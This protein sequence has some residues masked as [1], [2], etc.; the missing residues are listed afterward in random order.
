MAE[1][2]KKKRQ[3]YVPRLLLR[4]FSS[5]GESVAMVVLDTEKRI[6]TASIATQCQKPYFYGEDERLE[7]AFGVAESKFAKVLG[8]LARTH[9]DQRSDDDLYDVRQF[10]HYQRIRTVAAA[11]D[12]N[13]LFDLAF[14]QIIKHDAA[15]PDVDQD[16]FRLVVKDTQLRILRE[17]TFSTPL[18][19]DLDVKF[20]VSER[21]RGF[22]ITDHPVVLQN[23]WAEHHLRFKVARSTTGL[24][25]K[26]L[27]MFLPVSP[28]VCVCV[29]DPR[30]YAYGSPKSRTFSVG[31]R[32]I[33]LLNSL[34]VLNAYDSL[35]FD[36][37]ATP[38]EELQRLLK[39]RSAN[40][41]WRVHELEEGPARRRIDGMIGIPMSIDGA[42]I[43]LGSQ[44]NFVQVTD[45]HLYE[46]HDARS[47]PTRTPNPKAIVEQYEKFVLEQQ[48]PTQDIAGEPG[49][50]S[51]ANDGSGGTPPADGPKT[52]T[53]TGT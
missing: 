29:Y 14:K 9:L 44:L 2:P 35:Y 45:R 5:D 50:S 11:E 36:P 33:R 51:G 39:V 49:V 12:M 46:D 4:N 22:V 6:P 43:R 48:A 1:A 3:H 41:G 23:H 47:V 52:S 42:N 38:E 21:P 34:Q 8:D 27:Q 26:G 24:A 25:L 28:R 7:T 16:Q 32:D 17:G 20:A 40:A 30:T 19:L 31:L 18:L 15:F 37:V 10:T 13:D 53:A